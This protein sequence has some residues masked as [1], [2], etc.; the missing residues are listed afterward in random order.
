M[1]SVVAD[2]RA[3]PLAVANA[4]LS[5]AYVSFLGLGVQGVT[6]TWG[7]ML[8]GAYQNLETAPWLLFFPVR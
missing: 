5:E 1:I 8:D 2:G 4:I 7:K 6:A 3:Y